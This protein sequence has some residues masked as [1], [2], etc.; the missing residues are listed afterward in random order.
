MHRS[1]SRR[2]TLRLASIIVAGF[3][4]VKIAG[5]QAPPEHDHQQHKAL[6]RVHFQTSC[7]PAAQRLFDQAMLYQHSFWYRA[8]K[9]AFEDALKADPE[10]VIAYWGIAQSLLLNPF[11]PPAP[12]NLQEGLVAIEKAKSIGAKTQREND[13]I[14]AIGVLYAN[15]DKIAH[16]PRLQAYL[17]AT[18]EVALRHPDDD[19]AQ[20]YYALALNVAASPAD[21]SYALPLKAAAI[22]EPIFRRQPQHPGVAHYLV[23]SY[24]YP[25]IAAK[26]LDAAKRYAAI[27]GASP[28]ALH[29]PSHIFTRIGY[30]KESIDSNVASAQIAR[31]DK[32]PDDLL[33]AMD[34]LVYAC[35]Q[36]AE[37]GKARA[38]LDEMKTVIGV[39][40]ARHTGPFALAASPARYAVERGD[41][42]A[43]SAMPL[44]PTRFAHVDA[45]THFARALGAARTGQLDAAKSDLAKFTELR[46]KLRDAK[47]A[48]WSGQVDIQWQIATAWMQYATGDHEGALKA[49]SAAADAEDMTEKHVVTPGPLAPARELYGQMLM[50]RG[51]AR[52]A[53][54][55]FEATLK[56]EPRRL[57]ATLG[58]AHAA[59]KSGDTIKVR[60]YFAAA[61]AL[62][63]KADP[64]RAEIAAARKVVASQR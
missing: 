31:Q 64:I 42:K 30:W 40:A 38:V 17:K 56:K 3:S 33:H 54:A 36:L 2:A 22:L 32:E 26:G 47:D 53:L 58:A 29:M 48:Y 21:R 45:M 9:Q 61:V 39:N 8:S 28:H 27:A 14:G 46:D 62:A 20:I 5:A 52:E 7:K 57:G 43:A 50:E 19:E 16:G 15:H 34:Y 49:M 37:D 55:A 23:H 24:D 12:K 13:Y 60:Q 59:E 35:L 18:E 6:G 10:C 44:Q 1:R 63:E 11:A 41:W 4:L 25:A 51:M